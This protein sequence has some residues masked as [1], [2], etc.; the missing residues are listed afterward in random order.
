MFGRELMGKDTDHISCNMQSPLF[1]D[2]LPDT[3]A[4]KRCVQVKVFPHFGQPAWWR[5]GLMEKVVLETHG[6]GPPCCS[7]TSHFRVL[8]SRCL[9]FS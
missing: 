3:R 2:S 9:G 1:F 5:E 8:L 4:R 6:K 7:Q